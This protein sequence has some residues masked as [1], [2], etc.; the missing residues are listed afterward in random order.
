M[1]PKIEIHEPSLVTPRLSSRQQN[2]YN[3]GLLGHFSVSKRHNRPVDLPNTSREYDR[4]IWGPNLGGK[5]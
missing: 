4:E 1:S 5:W 2:L 3:V